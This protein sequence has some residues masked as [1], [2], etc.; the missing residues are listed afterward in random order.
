MTRLPIYQ[1]D[2]F[3]NE[4]FRGNPA[5]VM[6]L[7]K[8]LPDSTLQ[9]L[10]QENNLSETAF[11]VREPEGSEADYHIRWLTPTRRCPCAATP[12]WPVPGCCSTNW[13]GRVIR[14]A[15]VPAAVHWA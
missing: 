6:P 13:T 7:D 12:P 4:L 14:S 1:V 11:L 2:A 5:A 3:A 9:A 10:A 8:W 15:S